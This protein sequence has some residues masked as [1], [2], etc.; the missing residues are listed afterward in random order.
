VSR[1]RPRVRWILAGFVLLTIAVFRPTPWEVAHT[2]PEVDG[3]VGDGLLYTWAIGHVSQTIFSRPS[4]LFDGGMFH[5]ATDTLAFSDHM[6]GQALLGLPVWWLTIAEPFGPHAAGNALLEFNLLSLASYA[7]GATAAFAYTRAL[8]G[9]TPAALA[10]GIAFAFT[11]LRFR[12]PHYIQSLCT[13]FVP[14]TLLAW[15]R[16][17]ERRD[18]RSWSAWVACW[19]AHS[20]LG[21]YATIYFALVMGLLAAWAL[22]AAPARSDRRLGVGT[23]AAPIVALIVLAP[24]LWPYLRVRETLALQRSG[25]FQTFLPMLLPARGTSGARLLDVIGEH[26]FGPGLVVWGLVALGMVAGGRLRHEAGLPRRFVRQVNA[27]GLAAT[28]ALMMLPLAWTQRVPGLDLMRTTHR[29]FFIGLVFLAYFVAEGV[30]WLQ[31]RTTSA[32]A[33][34]LAGAALVA[35]VALDMGRPEGARREL[36]IVANVP[37]IYR[38][39]GAL[40]DGVVLDDF[41]TADGGAYA[42]YF[43]AFHG[44]RLVNG[45][46]GF[47][48]PWGDYE[49]ARVDMFPRDEATTLLWD[50]GVRH[51]VEH[52][53]TAA[54]AETWA[55]M[56]RPQYAHVETQLDT[57]LLVVLDAPPPPLPKGDTI[58]IGREGWRLTASDDAQSLEAVRDG[59]PHTGCRLPSDDV[60]AAVVVDLGRE[61]S[62]TGVRLVPVAVG[63]PTIYQANVEISRD[64][65]TW[66][67]PRTWFEPDDRDALVSR[68]RDVR[69]FEARFEPSPARFVRITNPRAGYR[70]PWWEIGELD[71][72]APAGAS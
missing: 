30:A 7:L 59:D 33:R 66:E 19:I 9:S 15:L 46:S 45:Y 51:V 18:R 2:I 12:S 3:V 24:T 70:A 58:P 21:M 10:A 40:P 4:A 67:R 69:F 52:F 57:A 71:L 41:P 49:L 31:E 53:D 55:R 27:F 65:E 44:K 62:L 38:L 48:G 28:I 60:A 36:P 14:L 16:F 50:L 32:R 63:D 23:L 39:V 54:Q 61:R 72:L 13:F 11:P 43:K 64:A 22:V 47:A 20:L 35:L 5:P 42:L 1:P 56:L 8:V 34:L 26:Q 25:G 17:V 68:P 37:E 29:P 6:I